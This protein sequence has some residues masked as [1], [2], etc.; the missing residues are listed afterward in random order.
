MRATDRFSRQ[1]PKGL[2]ENM[3]W[4]A[5]MHA[6]VTE[7]PKRIAAL[8]E[9]C[10]QDPIFF[11]NAFCYTYDPRPSSAGKPKP[12]SRVPFL[13]YP[14]QEE[15]IMDLARA[16]GFEDAVIEKT[17]DMGASWLCIIIIVWAWLFHKDLSFLLGS[18]VEAYVDDQGNPKSMFWKIDFILHNLPKWLLPRGFD[19]KLHRRKLHIENPELGSVID[20]E[21]TNDNFARGDRRTAIVLDEFAAVEQGWRILRATRDATDCRIFNSTPMGTNNAFY[22]VRNRKDIV[23][24]R[25]H[26]S[27]HPDKSIGTYTTD[28]NGLLEIL[29]PNGRDSW[30]DLFE[31][32]LDGK[33]RSPWYDRQCRRA[34]SAKDIAQEL[35]IDYLGS[36]YQ[37]FSPDTINRRIREHARPP[38]MVGD[39]EYD[40][41]TGEPIRF[42][43][44]QQ[45]HL[46][47]WILLDGAGN[48]PIEHKHTV[49]ADVSAGTGASNSA[50]SGWDNVTQ[51]KV[52]EYA[53]ANV[54]PEDFAR[55]AVAICRW[56]NRP[57]LIWESG[58]PGRQFGSRV[59]DLHYS[60]V[61]LRK[62]EEA[63]SKKVSDIPGVAQTKEV[64]AAILGAYR[65]TIEKDSGGVINRSKEALEEC[66]EYIHAPDG[67]IVHSRST[68]KDDPTGAK[69]N[70]G[71]RAMADA[72]AWKGMTEREKKLPS[73][74]G[75]KP[76]TPYGSLAWRNKKREERYNKKDRLSAGWRSH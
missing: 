1:I 70:H 47:L 31:P 59:L 24:I 74:E 33:L 35:D 4:R 61:Y 3:E 68:R 38:F 58:G 53:N 25:M 48:P 42:R 71:D 51:Q 22:D 49:G 14:F 36:V 50:L 60:N 20:G 21:S 18:R 41:D 37:F 27:V 52:F 15:A 30:P 7:D 5:R 73:D 63:L 69:A 16:L 12:F 11:I 44:D 8:K 43:E 26:W 6:S 75:N 72:L 9:A 76:K 57:Y 62:R 28:E 54:R 55:Q 17:R 46:K 23:K 40:N 34:A 56:F 65:I 2:R 39:L 10:K 45:G 66:L 67:S 19:R 32:I 13:L 29:D 64:K